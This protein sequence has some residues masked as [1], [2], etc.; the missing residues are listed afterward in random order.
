[1]PRLCNNLGL[2]CFFVFFCFVY[3]YIYMHI[4]VAF[5][6]MYRV[7]HCNL[8]SNG[9]KIFCQQVSKDCVHQMGMCM[10]QSLALSLVPL[11]ILACGFNVVLS[12][13][14]VLLH[15]LIQLNC[16]QWCNSVAASLS[17]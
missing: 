2:G 7:F 9:D 8:F 3:I 15:V 17:F 13:K 11:F 1:M 14:Q 16:P 10:L 4:N 12:K 5:I 6:E